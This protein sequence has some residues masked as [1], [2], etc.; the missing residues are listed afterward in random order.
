MPAP[1]FRGMRSWC[2]EP[3]AS[4]RL[5]CYIYRRARPSRWRAST[6]TTRS[7]AR[8]G[9]CRSARRSLGP[10]WRILTSIFAERF[11]ELRREAGDDALGQAPHDALLVRQVAEPPWIIGLEPGGV[12]E[13]PVQRD[14]EDA[15]EL[16]LVMNEGQDRLREVSHE[17][18][19]REVGHGGVDRV[20]DA[21]RR[22]AA[23]R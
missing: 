14:R 7:P 22:Q 16:A 17:R 15:V 2:A 5:R 9:S 20:P 19:H 13:Q 8:A 23:Q 12:I 10:S 18:H 3:S 4:R 21:E 11:P 1:A 6:T